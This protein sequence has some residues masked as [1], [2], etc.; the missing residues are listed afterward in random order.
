MN[1][2]ILYDGDCRFCNLAVQFIIKRDPKM[3]FKFAH[4]SS[5]SGKQLIDNLNIKNDEDSLI[6]IY[7]E[8]YFIQSTAALMISKKLNKGWPLLYGLIIIP[9]K[10]RNYIYQIVANNRYKLF[11]QATSCQLPS[12][13]DVQRFLL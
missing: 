1:A 12:P 8:N 5:K 4:L 6:V 9:K 3:Y 11:G 13:K 7:N 2:I 10:L